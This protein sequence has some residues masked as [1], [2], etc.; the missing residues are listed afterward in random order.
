MDIQHPPP[1]VLPPTRQLSVLRLPLPGAKQQ[2]HSHTLAALSN[3][4]ALGISFLKRTPSA[5]ISFYTRRRPVCL[6]G[7][8]LGAIRLHRGGPI[9]WPPHPLQKGQRHTKAR[10]ESRSALFNRRADS[11]FTP[12]RRGSNEMVS[13]CLQ[14][15]TDGMINRHQETD[16][17]AFG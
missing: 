7:R 14:T 12:P 5:L 9:V 16:G 2:Q 6:F 3:T 13:V 8:A 10:G 17:R 1:H 15:E 11:P 4:A